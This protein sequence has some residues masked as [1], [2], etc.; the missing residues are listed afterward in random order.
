MR[1]QRIQIQIAQCVCGGSTQ[2]KPPK[3][4]PNSYIEWWHSVHED[5]GVALDSTYGPVAC[6]SARVKRKPHTLPE[7]RPFG[8]VLPNDQEKINF[9]TYGSHMH[10]L[11]APCA[12]MW[13]PNGEHT[14]AFKLRATEKNVNPSP[15]HKIMM[16]KMNPLLPFTHCHR[17][18]YN[19]LW[20]DT[21]RLRISG[22]SLLHSLNFI[23]FHIICIYIYIY[24]YVYVYIYIYI[25]ICIYIYIYIDIYIYIYL[26]WHL[27]FHLHLY[28]HLQSHLHL[29]RPFAYQTSCMR[30]RFHCNF[31]Q[32]RKNGDVAVPKTMNK[33]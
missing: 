12:K 6:Q 19:I 14:A 21:A 24:I 4:P 31:F 11:F 13:R 30:S 29:L 22:I 2:T 9:F 28:L 17:A 1:S 23:S 26:H 33:L 16:R 8:N 7:L 10:V 5:P 18:T 20:T 25:Y 32:S 15:A 3:H 27:H